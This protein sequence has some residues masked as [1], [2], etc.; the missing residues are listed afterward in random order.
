MSRASLP[1]KVVLD[2]LTIAEVSVTC[3]ISTEWEETDAD[4]TPPVRRVK[5]TI[6]SSVLADNVADALRK[7]AA[8]LEGTELS[9]RE[10]RPRPA[11]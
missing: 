8:A 10:L 6:H 1:L 7:L 4:T 9:P 5:A 3:E 11:P 2:D